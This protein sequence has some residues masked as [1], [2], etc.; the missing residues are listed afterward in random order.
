MSL[1]KFYNLTTGSY[2]SQWDDGILLDSPNYAYIFGTQFSSKAK[3]DSDIEAAKT[4]L[5]STISSLQS[6]VESINTTNLEK[7]DEMLTRNVT[8]TITSLSDVSTS[9]AYY[10]CNISSNQTL[11]FT[12]SWKVNTSLHIFIYNSGTSEINVTIP[13]TGVYVNMS[14]ETLT[15]PAN[16]GGEIDAFADECG[17]VWLRHAPGELTISPDTTILDD[18]DHQLG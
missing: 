1:V 2:D 16:G 6:T 5:N 4:E 12:G 18:G 7:L 17:N 10:V 9:H 15:I 13:N 3:V 8:D 11:S 14:A